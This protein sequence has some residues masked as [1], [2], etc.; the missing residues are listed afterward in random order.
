MSRRHRRTLWSEVDS[1]KND[2]VHVY[3]CIESGNQELERWPSGSEYLLPLHK[4]QV[5][6][7]APT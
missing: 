3:Q 5:Q 7:P 6:F 4:T 2:V 1:S